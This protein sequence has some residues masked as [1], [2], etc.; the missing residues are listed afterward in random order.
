[1]P[2]FIIV[3]AQKSGT[4][5]LYHYL[6]QHPSL[7]SSYGKE[8]HFFD[9]GLRARI[10]N[11]RKGP[12]WYRAHFPTRKQ[13]PPGGKT[14]EATPLY[15][16]NPLVP[17][18]MSRLVPDAKLIILMRNPVERAISHFF[19]EKR[20][21]REPLRILEALQS[22]EER[23]A[24]AMA[25][26]DFMDPSFIRHSY[27]LRGVYHEQ[28]ARYLE[29]YPRENMLFLCSEEFFADPQRVL[30][31]VFRFLDVDE[32]FR[33]T[34][35]EPRNA[36]ANRVETDGEVYGYLEDFFRFH[37]QRLYE[38]TGER[39]GWNAEPERSGEASR[40]FR[41]REAVIE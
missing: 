25:R 21:G 9:G 2:D 3:G 8:V 22:E 24:P 28:I 35:L 33:I 36:A 34:D 14:F 29:W 13:L 26:R 12:S 5:S 38:L 31:R 10:D 18:R 32:E 1:M 4:S 23:L 39:Y 41:V 17:E 27:K 40:F 30:R 6:G 16:F 20:K 37:N 15:L 19:H 11:Y 7:F